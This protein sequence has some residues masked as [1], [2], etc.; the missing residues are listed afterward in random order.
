MASQFVEAI[1]TTASTELAGLVEQRLL[2]PAASIGIELPVIGVSEVPDRPVLAYAGDRPWYFCDHI[3]DPTARRLDG[4]IPVP[5][6]E[7]Q[8][9]VFLRDAGVRPDLVWLGHE[10]PPDWREDE[11]LPDLVPPDVRPVV[12]PGTLT[13]GGQQ[14]AVQV[15]RGV[16]DGTLGR[17]RAFGSALERLDPIVLGGVTDADGEQVAWVELARWTW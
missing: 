3:E 6:A 14:R 10:L 9:L 15:V 8:R 13:V 2:T 12:R 7:H 16:V 17:L 5:E 4:Y 1:S 11:E